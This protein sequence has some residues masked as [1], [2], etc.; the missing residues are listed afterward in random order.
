M[1][2]LH[3]LSQGLIVQMDLASSKAVELRLVKSPI[4]LPSSRASSI[5][6]Q[7]LGSQAESAR[8]IS[9]G[10]SRQFNV[11]QG[12]SSNDSLLETSVVNSNIDLVDFSDAL[13]MVEKSLKEVAEIKA[14][15]L[16]EAAEWK[17]KYEMEHL[18]CLHLENCALGANS[19]SSQKLPEIKNMANEVLELSAADVTTT[20]QQ[21]SQSNNKQFIR[22]HSSS[23]ENP[24]T[25]PKTKFGPEKAMFK[26]V[27]SH[28]LH[29]SDEQRSVSVEFGNISTEVQSN[30]QILL[31]WETPPKSVVIIT[32]PNAPTV[33]KLCKEMIK[34]LRDEK[35]MKVYTEPIVKEE[36]LKE[37]L[38]FSCVQTCETDQELLELHNK[39]D[40]VI[41]LGGDG[42]LI[43]AA[44]MFKGPIPPVVAFSM[45]SLGFMT[46]FQSDHYRECL[47]TVMRGPVFITLRHRLV[48]QIVRDPQNMEDGGP[49]V[50]HYLV[51][52]EV[53]IGRGLSP[54]L[55]NLECY[56]DGLFLTSVQGDGLILSTPSGSTA[57][58]LAAGGSM[59]HPQV[60]GILFTPICPH[61][62]SFRPL[63]LPESVTLKVQVPKNSRDQAWA[64]F[65]GKSRQQLSKDVV[66]EIAPFD[67]CWR[68][69]LSGNPSCLTFGLHLGS[70]S[71]L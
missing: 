69:C 5:S 57:Y 19:S 3:V 50:E 8:S 62:L 10:T 35:D 36:L 53:S 26:L 70:T 65:D 68:E 27:W 11:E 52:N 15:A 17:R 54:Y 37:S 66:M 40:L 13:Q 43:W 51:L 16:A 61:S 2:S 42:T 6:R 34:W 48:C 39:V 38:Y 23:L 55:S 64:S 44:S 7:A 9:R 25:L 28:G 49:E 31:V 41:T 46:Q 60:P 22:S 71:G 47:Q 18:Q 59:V 45:G 1:G 33:Q 63:L 67:L 58:S 56:C 24:G 4:I 29:Q 30:K 14:Q 20:G 12:P 32:K 21:S